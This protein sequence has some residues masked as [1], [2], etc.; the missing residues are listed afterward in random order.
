MAMKL[1][2]TFSTTAMR[3]SVLAVFVIAASL[4]SAAQAA[5]ITMSPGPV[6]FQGIRGDFTLSLQGGD[7]SDNRLVFGLLGSNPP[8][9]LPAVGV[10]ALVFH[11]VSVVSAGEISDPHSLIT[12]ISIPGTGTVTGLLV[13]YNAPSTA[14]FF[15][16]LSG[17]PASATIYSLTPTLSMSL[18]RYSTHSWISKT[19]VRFDSAAIPEPGAALCFAAGLAL[20]ASRIRRP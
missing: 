5:P 15:V 10:A 2:D 8:G 6:T 18:S 13:D 12:G 16:R 20:V 14:S 3:R 4:A 7:T 17:T 1:Q 9:S 11:G 19:E